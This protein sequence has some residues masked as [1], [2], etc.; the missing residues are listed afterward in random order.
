MKTA[1][2]LCL[3]VLLMSCV[4]LEDRPMQLKSGSGPIYPSAAKAEGVEGAVVVRYGV[5]VDGRVINA[6]IDSA[7]P[8]GVF[9]EAALKA[10]RSWRYNP[11]IRDGSPVAVENILSTVRF[12]LG[13]GGE[14]DEY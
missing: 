12:E 4:A 3:L 8:S 2:G 5:S 6:R 9:D 14:Y 13:D 11:A 7:Q 10:V 1:V